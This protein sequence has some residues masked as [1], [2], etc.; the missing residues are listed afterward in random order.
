MTSK[1]YTE[2][3]GHAA[4]QAIIASIVSRIVLKDVILQRRTFLNRYKE[5][6]LRANLNPAHTALG[7]ESLNHEKVGYEGVTCFNNAVPR[8]QRL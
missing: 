7:G 6:E 4:G 2:S 3:A 5:A 1:G 8:F